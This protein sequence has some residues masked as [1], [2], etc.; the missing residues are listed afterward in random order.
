MEI[1][2]ISSADAYMTQG[3]RKSIISYIRPMF[4]FILNFEKLPYFEADTND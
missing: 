1:P 4:V 3:R 2:A